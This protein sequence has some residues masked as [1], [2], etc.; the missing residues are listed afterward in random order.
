MSKKII[1]IEDEKVIND[2]IK[3]IIGNTFD[4]VEIEQYFDIPKDHQNVL[5]NCDLLVM[6]CNLPSGFI[7]DSECFKKCDIPKILI[8]GDVTVSCQGNNCHMLYKP[9]RFEEIVELVKN[10]LDI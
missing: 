1:I 3:C 5:A 6:D 8:T 2:I 10:I 9:F 7:C 4:D